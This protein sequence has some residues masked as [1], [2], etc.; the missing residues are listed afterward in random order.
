MLRLC[1][2]LIFTC[3]RNRAYGIKKPDWAFAKKNRAGMC[4]GVAGYPT[5]RPSNGNMHHLSGPVVCIALL[6]LR[7]AGHR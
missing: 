7:V 6:V 3:R 1:E 2:R 4:D 5:G